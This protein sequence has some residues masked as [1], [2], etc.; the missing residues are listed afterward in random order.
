MNEFLF[1]AFLLHS[2]VAGAFPR[3][4][5]FIC[6]AVIVLPAAALLFQALGYCFGKCSSRLHI[7]S[8]CTAVY[9]K[10]QE[11]L[12]SNGILTVEFSRA[13]A[14][15]SQLYPAR[16]M[17]KF[18]TSQLNQKNQSLHITEKTVATQNIK[19]KMNGFSFQRH[20]GKMVIRG[21]TRRRRLVIRIC[22]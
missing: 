14:T 8:A 4:R 17:T 12:A 1:Q 18:Q 20:A 5:Q 19:C 9:R 7:H 6:S 10:E 11:W 22:F 21:A 15:R 13:R 16:L 2:R 3:L